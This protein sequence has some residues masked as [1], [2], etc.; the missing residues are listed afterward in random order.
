MDYQTSLLDQE[1]PALLLYQKQAV[2]KADY[3]HA[4]AQSEKENLLKLNYNNKIEIIANGI[5]VKNVALKTSW[6]RK[7]EN[8]IS[9]TH[10]HKKRY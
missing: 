6:N 7:K 9:F 5:E 8:I 3:L 1:V 2:V 10:T 4:T